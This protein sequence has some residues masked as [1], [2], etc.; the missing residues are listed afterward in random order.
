MTLPSSQHLGSSFS[1]HGSR[2]RVAPG[3]RYGHRPVCSFE[4]TRERELLQ[5]MTDVSDDEQNVAD[6]A[7]AIS[8]AE[9]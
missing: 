5:W 7:N 9:Y 6:S 2:R 8:N 4:M 3:R 1:A